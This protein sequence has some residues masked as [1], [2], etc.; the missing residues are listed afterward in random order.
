[1]DEFRQASMSIRDI[2]EGGLGKNWQHSRG[3]KEPSPNSGTVHLEL[4]AIINSSVSLQDFTRNLRV[5][6]EKW[7][8]GGESV[9]PP[10]LRNKL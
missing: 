4:A 6:A 5:W 10:I 3:I 2:N 8:H 1:M 9:L 7:F